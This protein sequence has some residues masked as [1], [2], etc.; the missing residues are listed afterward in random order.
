MT[1][2][3]VLNDIISVFP[4]VAA[5]LLFV[6]AGTI[7]ILGFTKRGMNFIKYGFGQTALDNLLLTES[8]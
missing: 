4:P 7:F 1:G 2:W 6:T 8:C 5:A 3:D